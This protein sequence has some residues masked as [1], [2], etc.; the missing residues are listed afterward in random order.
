MVVIEVTAL[1]FIN[2]AYFLD[3]FGTR[4]FFTPIIVFVFSCAILFINLVVFI[5][6]TFHISKIRKKTNFELVTL[7]GG[8]V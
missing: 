6:L 2:L 1:I 3:L 8:D 7:L 4:E 5:L